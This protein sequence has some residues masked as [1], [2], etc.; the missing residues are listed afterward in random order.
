MPG[1]ISKFDRKSKKVIKTY[2]HD[3]KNIY[4]MPDAG[5]INMFIEDNKNSNIHWLASAGGLIE[6]NKT[7]ENFPSTLMMTAEK[8]INQTTV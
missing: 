6:F 1:T 3:P 7:T 5:H 2:F 8:F 4:S